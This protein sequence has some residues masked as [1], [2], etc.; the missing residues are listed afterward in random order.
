MTNYENL[1]EKGVCRRELCKKQREIR[2]RQ[3]SVNESV[4]GRAALWLLVSCNVCDV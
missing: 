4:V 2:N 3:R 1:A